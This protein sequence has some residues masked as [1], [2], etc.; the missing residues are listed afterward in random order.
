MTGSVSEIY[1]ALRDSFEAFAIA[2]SYAYEK[3]GI[4]FRPPQDTVWLRFLFK[5]APPRARV[6]GSGF[7]SQERGYVT[8]EVHVPE[9]MGEG[10]A[11]GVAKAVSDNYWP[12]G[13]CNNIVRGSP[14]ITTRINAPP[15]IEPRED[16]PG[17][18]TIPVTVPWFADIPA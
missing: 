10:F 18:I 5:P 15:Y 12:T 14:P 7:K 13:V 9:K 8:V 6:V 11:R 4:L 3:S 17:F 16:S 1:G 2:N